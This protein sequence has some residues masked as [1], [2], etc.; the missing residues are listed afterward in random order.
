[1]LRF[2]RPLELQLLG[3]QA[4]AALGN[5]PMNLGGT[6][7]TS[8]PAEACTSSWTALLGKLRR[9]G[10]HAPMPENA[11]LGCAVH[12][13]AGPFLAV[14]GPPLFLQALITSGEPTPRCGPCC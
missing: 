14:S 8:S 7:P 9:L 1:M 12:R 13:R 10:G 5:L 4:P 2:E 6:V 3:P 11:V